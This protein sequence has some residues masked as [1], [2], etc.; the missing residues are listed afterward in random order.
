MSFQRGGESNRCQEEIASN[1]PKS[2]RDTRPRERSLGAVDDYHQF[3]G[4]VMRISNWDYR[5]PLSTS[6]N[7]NSSLAGVGQEDDHHNRTYRLVTDKAPLCYKNAAVVD[8]YGGG[9]PMSTASG[10]DQE[11]FLMNKN[12]KCKN[13]EN[14]QFRD[15]IPQNR[16]EISTTHPLFMKKSPAQCRRVFDQQKNEEQENFA[17]KEV[18]MQNS[19][20][21]RSLASPDE[22]SFLRNELD[23]RDS[24]GSFDSLFDTLKAIHD[25]ESD[26]LIGVQLDG[27]S[28]ISNNSP[29]NILDSFLRKSPGPPL[30]EP[31]QERK[32]FDG[33]GLRSSSYNCS[34]GSSDDLLLHQ[35]TRSYPIEE[36]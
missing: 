21:E 3:N 5:G 4:N 8:S 14:I 36:G 26:Q 30:V 2:T 23:R 10:L 27:A 24:C 13:H 20:I 9:E 18:N 35:L 32:V 34:H 16:S 33:L 17:I 6:R 28:E 1:F 25:A 31:L 15:T 22:E 11:N 19:M 29:S 12:D 7:T